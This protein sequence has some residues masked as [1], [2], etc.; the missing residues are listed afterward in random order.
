MDSLDVLLLPELMP[1]ENAAIKLD[2]QKAHWSSCSVDLPILPNQKCIHTICA[3]LPKSILRIKGCTK[4]AE[5]LD[6][7]YFERTPNGEVYIRPFRG[8][9][10]TGSKLISI[11]PGSTPAVLEHA[12]KESLVVEL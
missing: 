7:T 4:I 6:Y 8:I 11:G 3:M 2:H 5:D 10:I 12:I 1:S 9:P